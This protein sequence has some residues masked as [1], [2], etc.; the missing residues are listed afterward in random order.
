MQYLKIFDL[1]FVHIQVHD[2]TGGAEAVA[3][4]NQMAELGFGEELLLC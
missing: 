3:G 4:L 1:Q 2:I